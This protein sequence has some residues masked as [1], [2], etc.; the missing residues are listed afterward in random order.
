MATVAIGNACFESV[1][2][3]NG[4][5]PGLTAE[6]FAHERGFRNV[7]EGGGTLS[8]AAGAPPGPF[9]RIT[10]SPF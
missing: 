7:F 8:L 2:D 6:N 1:P 5:R 3:R 9:V 4:C 10:P